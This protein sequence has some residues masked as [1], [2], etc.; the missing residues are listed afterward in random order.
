MG[1]IRG[2]GAL[3]F[4][5]LLFAPACGSSGEGGNGI[6]GNGGSGAVGGNSGTSGK[7]GS[8]GNS[9]SGGTSGSGGNSG[10]AGTSGSGGSIDCVDEPTHSGD[11]TYYAA[12][13]SGNCTFD[14]SPSDLRVAAMNQTDYLNSRACGACAQITGPLG[15]ITVRIVDRCP[16]CP[17]GDVD[18]SR[19]AFAEIAE[20]PQGRVDIRWK[21]VSCAVTGAVRYRF[22][23]GSSEFWTA[24][25]VR[26]HRNAIAKLEYQK[27]GAYVNVTREEYN[28]FVEADGMGPGPYTFRVTDVYGNQIVDT[29]VA[30]AEAREVQGKGQFPACR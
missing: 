8:G 16:E 1:V 23:E 2:Y 15:E 22:K 14:P 5:P 9:G 4:V 18:L 27:G 10:G 29:G 6:G 28:Y 20:I 13:G 24:V 19:E 21:Y 26:N 12:D 11:G 17:K 7:A 30:F 3:A 25:Q